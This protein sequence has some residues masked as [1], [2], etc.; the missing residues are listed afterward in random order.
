MKQVVLV[1][2]MILLCGEV[3][4]SFDALPALNI[5]IQETSVSGLSSGGFFAVQMQVAYS[6]ILKGAG[7]TFFIIFLNF[8]SFFYLIFFF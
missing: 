3:V 7:T 5:D 2:V 4:Y 8:C 6:S 1:F